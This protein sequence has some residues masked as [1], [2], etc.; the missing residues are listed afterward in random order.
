MQ[1]DMSGKITTAADF[2]A[3]LERGE[4]FSEVLAQVDVPMRASRPNLESRR[5]NLDLPA[6]MV[7]ALDQRSRRYGMS[8]QAVIKM[9]LAQQL[10]HLPR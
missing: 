8:R 9:I 4:D 5:I 1:F 10:D 7:Q 2:D 6:W 3:A